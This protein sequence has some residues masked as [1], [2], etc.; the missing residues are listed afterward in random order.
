L[1]REI[2]SN[3]AS[4]LTKFEFVPGEKIIL[5]RHLEIEGQFQIAKFTKIQILR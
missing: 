3:V 2:E 1:W 5:S 4:E